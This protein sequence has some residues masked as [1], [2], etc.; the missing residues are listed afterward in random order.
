MHWMSQTAQETGA[1]WLTPT[2]LVAMVVGGITLIGL[3]IALIEIHLNRQHNLRMV[4]PRLGWIF[5]TPYEP[6]FTIS[7]SVKNVGFAAAIVTKMEVYARGEP[8]HP[9]HRPEDW[10]AVFRH[11]G[12]PP[13]TGNAGVFGAREASLAA[14]SDF[15][16]YEITTHIDGTPLSEDEFHD[17]RQKL[18]DDLAIRI[19][20]ESVAGEKMDAA[21]VLG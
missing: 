18:E 5:R 9:S 10:A 14:G 15:L 19:S 16:L 2:L 6:A 7:L 3:V 21:I 20:Y 17:Y 1:D 8:F 4:R 12:I 11:L 13:T